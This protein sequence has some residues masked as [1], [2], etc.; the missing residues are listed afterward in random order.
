[1]SLSQWMEGLRKDFKEDF[2]KYLATIAL[3]AVVVPLGLALVTMP[4]LAI[5]AVLM[6][7][8]FTMIV[9]LGPLFLLV[10]IVGS[11]HYSSEIERFK[12]VLHSYSCAL[13]YGGLC[14]LHPLF[15]QFLKLTSKK[16]TTPSPELRALG[17]IIKLTRQRGKKYT[18]EMFR[19]TCQ[20][21]AI[22]FWYKKAVHRDVWNVRATEPV[23]EI[24]CHYLRTALC[25]EASPSTIFYLHGGGFIAGS[26]SV[27]RGMIAPLATQLNCNVFAVEYRKMPEY[28]LPAAVND[29]VAAYK[30]LTVTRG[31]S[32]E[33]ILFAGDSAGGSLCLL[34]LIALKDEGLPLP[35]GA[36]L[37]S[38][39]V[40]LTVSSD[41][42]LRNRGKDFILEPR[43]IDAARSMFTESPTFTVED[44]KKFSP[45]LFPSSRLA[46][47]PPLFISAGTYEPLIDE[48]NTFVAKLKQA[49]VP[50]EYIVKESCPHVFQMFYSFCPEARETMDK[51]ILFMDNCLSRK[52]RS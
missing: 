11:F 9:A 10:G 18:L 26:A 14:V 4:V 37:M 12:N 50:H 21:Y 43:I 41:S 29:A 24:P 52:A 45:A 19:K 20:G 27:Y 35:A 16:G 44:A 47:L 48:I 30:Y 28:P 40:D 17:A 15:T 2:L 34:T 6:P 51:G 38:P 32:P 8:L 36:L 22:L 33:R 23:R 5:I 25:P 49:S 46:D 1:M 7:L 39:Y 3:L 13:A 42:W 31:L